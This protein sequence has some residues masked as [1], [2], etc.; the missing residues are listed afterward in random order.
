MSSLPANQRAR[1]RVLQLG[2]LLSLLPLLTIHPMFSADGSRFVEYLGVLLVL[3]CV[4]GRM[5]SVLYIGTKKNVELVTAGPYSTTRNPL[6]FFSVIGAVGIG[7]FMGSFT[8]A[9][10]FGLAAYLVLSATARK[11]AAY[12][13]KLFG[14]AY[15]NYARSTPIFW[16]KLSLYREADEPTF[17]PV[18]LKRTFLDGLL[19]FAALP[20]VELF[21]MVRDSN[22]FPV[23]L[24]IF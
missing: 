7:L 19:F 22:H 10:T 14:A 9:A 23:L 21:E 5:W 4:G 13:E 2:A 20:A 1:I 18:A 24:G 11:E 3:V 8:L 15:R 6:Y 17:S 16:P 12:L